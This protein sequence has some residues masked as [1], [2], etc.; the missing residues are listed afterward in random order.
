MIVPLASNTR[1]V[2]RGTIRSRDTWNVSL[3][4]F[5]NGLPVGAEYPCNVNGKTCFVTLPITLSLSVFRKRGISISLKYNFWNDKFIRLCIH[6]T[7]R[8]SDRV[9]GPRESPCTISVLRLGRIVVIGIYTT[10]RTALA[11]FNVEAVVSVR[12]SYV[13][14]KLLCYIM[15]VY[16]EEKRKQPVVY[17]Y[18]LYLWY[19][20]LHMCQLS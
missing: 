10:L 6:T 5:I 18:I 8:L 17:S 1:V 16:M 11:I 7:K 20:C 2:W 3:I 14:W 15:Y 9:K 13:T 4:L 12:H 19:V